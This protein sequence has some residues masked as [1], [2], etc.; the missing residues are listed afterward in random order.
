MLLPGL[1]SLLLYY[2]GL[3]VTKA[4]YATL[5]EL[6]FPL[7]GMVV[8]WLVFQE[9]VT[10]AQVVGFALIWIALFCVARQQE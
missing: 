9:V 1:L 8:N 5:A 3:A 10:V 7:V 4:S 6:S 2:R